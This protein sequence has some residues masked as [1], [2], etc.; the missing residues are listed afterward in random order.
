VKHSYLP[1]LIV[2]ALLL[3]AARN[4]PIN[5]SPNGTCA[6][7][8][9]RSQIAQ[10]NATQTGPNS[11]QSS[12]ATPT[13]E[14]SKSPNLNNHQRD[15]ESSAQKEATYTGLLVI[16]GLLAII[17]NYCAAKSAAVAALDSAKAANLALQAVRPFVLL[18]KLEMRNFEPRSG[19]TS[20]SIQTVADVTVTN[21]GNGPAIITKIIARMKVTAR[22][23]LQRDPPDFT[24]CQEMWAVWIQ[25]NVIA[26][27]GIAS[28]LVRFDDGNLVDESYYK[29]K[30]HDTGLAL[31]GVI[32]Y[33]D[34]FEGIYEMTFGF[35]YS[36]GY[37]DAGEGHW[38]FQ[39]GPKE[40]NRHR[41]TTQK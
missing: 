26:A 18:D 14:Q 33:E 2:A 5:P 12:T 15:A 41:Q 10:P 3:S 39:A 25:P 8:S 27:K 28:F 1:I 23:F 21:A 37:D 13:P 22:P 34:V 4:E 11:S 35:L 36:W 16:V 30:A 24:D 19:L 29:L 20:S 32:T 17:L 40:Y 9:E 6:R 7:E 31:Y 38:S